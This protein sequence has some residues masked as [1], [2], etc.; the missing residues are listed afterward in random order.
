MC[1]L[2]NIKTTSIIDCYQD[3]KR[4]STTKTKSVYEKNIAYHA[5]NSFKTDE[6]VGMF[7][8]TSQESV[9]GYHISK[10]ILSRR[11]RHAP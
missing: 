2:F 3:V 11:G 7:C 1:P 5:F 10:H 8:L 4:V 9:L 6:I